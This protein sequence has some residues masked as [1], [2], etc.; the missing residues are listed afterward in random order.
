MGERE[1][2]HSRAQMDCTNWGGLVIQ[3][4]V[5]WREVLD[6][7]IF[8]GRVISWFLANLGFCKSLFKVNIWGWHLAAK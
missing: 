5:N 6:N 2:K 7:R 8:Y 3:A 4:L 1:G